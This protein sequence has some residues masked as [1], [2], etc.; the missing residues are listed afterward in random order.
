MGFGIRSSQVLGRG[1]AGGAEDAESVQIEEYFKEVFIAVS[2][3]PLILS[4][5]IDYE[6][7]SGTLGI[8][9]GNIVFNDN[10]TLEFLELVRIVS[11]RTTRPKYR[12]HYY[13]NEELIFRYD[14]AKHHS[15]VE[16]FPHH[17]HVKSTVTSSPE[18]SLI[19]VL[20]EIEKRLI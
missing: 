4:F 12:F 3:N 8:I 5:E 10:T 18:K 19:D 2:E 13:K 6:V 15:E 1:Q 20:G 14:N 16:T 7:K 11:D 17:K 9:F